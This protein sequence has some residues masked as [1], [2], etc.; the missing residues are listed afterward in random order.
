M[1]SLTKIGKKVVR[2][3]RE[4]LGIGRALEGTLNNRTLNN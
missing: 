1:V 2:T 3:R 4:L